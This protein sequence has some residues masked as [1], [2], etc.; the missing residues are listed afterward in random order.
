MQ[1]GQ[2]SLTGYAHGVTARDA[3]GHLVHA[4]CRKKN[5]IPPLKDSRNEADWI[6]FTLCFFSGQKK[7]N[8]IFLIMNSPL[9][10]LWIGCCSGCTECE[11]AVVAFSPM[12][13]S[14]NAGESCFSG[15]CWQRQFRLESAFNGTRMPAHSLQRKRHSGSLHVLG[16]RE[17]ETPDASSSDQL[18]DRGLLPR[19]VALVLPNPSSCVNPS[20]LCVRNSTLAPRLYLLARCYQGGQVGVSHLDCQG[21]SASFK[22]WR[23][24][25]LFSGRSLA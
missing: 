1:W 2:I 21:C 16:L 19:Q 6:P 9:T 8:N 3:E 12:D 5:T 24:H 25:I 11:G 14:E 15:Q 20:A 4:A 22:P 10:V 23:K 13:M 18:P 17:N 7:R